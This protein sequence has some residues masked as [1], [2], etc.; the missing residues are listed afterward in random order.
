MNGLSVLVFFGNTSKVL[1]KILNTVNNIA[2]IVVIL[3][4]A[5]ALL[6]TWAIFQGAGVSSSLLIYKPELNYQEEENPSITELVAMYPDVRAWLTIEETSIDYPVVQGAD[7]TQYVNYNVEG[8]FSLSG[9]IF[10]DCQNSGDFSDLYSIIY[11]HHMDTSSMFGGLDSFADEEYLYS[12]TVGYLFL[13]NTTEEF[14]IF[15]YMSV[16]AYDSYIFTPNYTDQESQQELIDYILE[17]ATVLTDI[18]LNSSDKIVAFST[19]SS[20]GTD[21]RTVV[22]AKLI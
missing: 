20:S 13:P 4:G 8:D 2:L 5:F 3:F 9:S 1:N 15:A 19:C 10:L 22:L 18:N 6:D 11:G 17:N 14:E 21:A 16:D 7:N 12:H